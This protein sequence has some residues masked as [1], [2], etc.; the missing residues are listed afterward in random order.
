LLFQ[1]VDEV[2]EAIGIDHTGVRISPNGH[3][4]A[5]SEDPETEET[6]LYLAAELDRRTVWYLHINDQAKFGMPAIPQALI[7]K[8][9]KAFH[10]PIILCGGC[11]AP[12]PER[13]IGE[14][15]ADLVAFG[16][17]YIACQS[18]PSGPARTGLAVQRTGSKQLL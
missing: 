2:A 16:V 3:F 13:A 14:G 8:I 12:H 5:M 4:N 18:Q 6:Y 10:G 1:V 9:R 11:D 15:I 17:P 7:P